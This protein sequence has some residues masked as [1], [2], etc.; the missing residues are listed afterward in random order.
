MRCSMSTRAILWLGL[1]LVAW[2]VGAADRGFHLPDA[3]PIE[4]RPG[5]TGDLHHHDRVHSSHLEHPRGVWV[6]LP[7]G[8]HEVSRRYPV[9][10]LHDGNNLFDPSSAFLGREWHLDEVLERMI[11]TGHLPPLIAVGVGNS[12]ARLEEYT[13]RSG[14]HDG[15]QVGGRGESYARFLVEELKPAIDEA[16]RTRPGRE[17][18]AVMGSSLGGLVSLYLARD[19]AETFGT[20]AAVSPSVWWAGRQVLPD[21]ASLRSDFRLWIDIGTEEGDPGPPGTVRP[22]VQNLRDLRE[23]LENRGYR[24][25]ESLGYLEDQGARHD[26]PSW[27]RRLP[28]I[29]SFL[30]VRE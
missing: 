1:T 22:T 15:R 6:W 5:V 26:E 11:H 16:Y 24:A 7:P 20:I 3:S 29:L 13:H 21:L 10:Y 25:G 30:Y 2:P 8:Y 17:H 23:V 18:T 19:H 4:G 28:E 12:P 9:L 14:E 27:S